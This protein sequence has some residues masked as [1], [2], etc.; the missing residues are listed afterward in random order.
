LTQ[1]IGA[2]DGAYDY[3]TELS[4]QEADLVVQQRKESHT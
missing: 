3:L 1:G 2:F 4:G